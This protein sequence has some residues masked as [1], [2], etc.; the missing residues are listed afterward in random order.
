MNKELQPDEKEEI[1]KS[2]IKREMRALQA[3][4]ERLAGLKP[5]LWEQ[6]GFSPEMLGAL[7]ES[8]RI[9]SHIARRR[10]FRRLGKLLRHEDR[11]RVHA[12][13]ERMDNAHLEDS[14]RFH[15]LEQWRDRLLTGG[16]PVL[17][18]LIARC[19]GADRQRLRQLVR[20]ARKEAQREQPPAA[21]R[22]LFR[23][24]K[25]LEID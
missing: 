19:P 23:Y 3:L 17:N 7:E 22:R 10:H 2:E 1:S 24:L 16:D 25:E 18:E 4:G 20:Q 6:F 12:L 14:R 8:R 11:E 21:S 15:R 9:R 13:F 5:A